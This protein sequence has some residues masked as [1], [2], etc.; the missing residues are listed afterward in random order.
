MS[1]TNKKSV[2]KRKSERTVSPAFAKRRRQEI[3]NRH[4]TIVVKSDPMA[5]REMHPKQE[6]TR[7]RQK[8]STPPKMKRK[9]AEVITIIVENMGGIPFSIAQ[10]SNRIGQCEH[11][12]DAI[13]DLLTTLY[14]LGV[15]HGIYVSQEQLNGWKPPVGC[16]HPRDITAEY[17]QEMLTRLKDLHSRPAP[18][19]QY[20]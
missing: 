20:N 9:P 10:L 3:Q 11:E 2:L 19:S 7:Q 5:K 18:T 12:Q 6:K 15:S 1:N 13:M 16:P 8:P 4:A 17:L 14:K